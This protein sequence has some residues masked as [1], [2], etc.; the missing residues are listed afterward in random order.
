IEST[1]L[2]RGQS[3]A[4]DARMRLPCQGLLERLRQARFANAGLSAEHHDLALSVFCLPPALP[5]QCHLLIPAHKR[6]QAFCDRDLKTAL[7]RARLE[8]LV[9]CEWLR[10]R[11][12]AMGTHG[13]VIQFSNLI[14]MRVKARSGWAAKRRHAAALLE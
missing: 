12:K 6:R 13:R 9:H 8:N 11:V 5:E 7:G 10:E 3:A 1:L 2:V 14:P 4:L